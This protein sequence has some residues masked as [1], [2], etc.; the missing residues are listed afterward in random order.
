M[1]RW[2]TR[3]RGLGAAVVL[4]AVA[5]IAVPAWGADDDPGDNATVEVASDSA[6]DGGVVMLPAHGDL[7]DLP[8]LPSAEDRKKIDQCMTDHG[9]GPGTQAT[10]VPAPPDAGAD[11]QQ[12]DGQAFEAPEPDPA[13]KRAAED[14]GLPAPPPGKAIAVAIAGDRNG[15]ELCPPPPLTLHDDQDGDGN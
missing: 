7:Q 12:G 8:P 10:P 2:T 5:A 3:E 4:M 6:G 11:N 15:D 9:F 13:F 1:S 14:C